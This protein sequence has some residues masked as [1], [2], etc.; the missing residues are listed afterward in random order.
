MPTGIG[1]RGLQKVMI[2]SDEYDAIRLADHE[3]LS[4]KDAALQMEVSA[5]TFCRILKKA[6]AKIADALLHNK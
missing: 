2:E 1:R 4:M 3:G 5:A 6:H